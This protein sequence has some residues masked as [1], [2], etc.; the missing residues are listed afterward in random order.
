MLLFKLTVFLLQ[1]SGRKNG[2]LSL[3]DYAVEENQRDNKAVYPYIVHIESSTWYMAK[4]A[5]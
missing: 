4:D 5:E 3:E 2:E 1:G